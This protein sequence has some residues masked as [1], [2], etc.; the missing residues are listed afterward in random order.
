MGVLCEDAELGRF[1]VPLCET[2][3]TVVDV[4][5][6]EVLVVEVPVPVD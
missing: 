4:L 1:A 5:V 2:V 6:V 3:E